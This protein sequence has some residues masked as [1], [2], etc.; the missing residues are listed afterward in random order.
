MSLKDLFQVKKV[1]AP[2]SNEQIAEEVESVQLMDSYSKDKNRVEF[3]VNYSTASNFAIFGSAE[4]YY[5]DTIQ[6][7][8]SQYPYDGSKKEKL[9]WYNSSSLLDIWF[10]ENAYPKTTGY[11]TFS[12]S[13]WGLSSS[14]MVSG[15]GNPASKEYI[16]I[17]GGPNTNSALTLKGQFTDTSNQYPKSNILDSSTNRLS[18]LQ[19]NLNEGVTLEFWLN[20]S[21]FI[22]SST[23]KEVIFDLWNN[24][25]SSSSGYGR[26]TLELSG[27]TGSPFYITAQSGTNGVFRQNIGSTPTTSS[28]NG[29]NHYAVSLYNTSSVIQAKFYLNGELDSTHSLGTSINEITGALIANIGAL[30]TA[31]SGT[32][33]ISLGWGKLSASIDDFRFWKEARTSREIGRNYWDSVG[34]GVNTDDANTTLG[35]Y[36]KFNEGI[37]TTSS[38][39][40][41]V[42]DYSG[43][44]S[45]GTW[46]GYTAPSRNTGS[47]ITNEAPDPIIYITHPDVVAVAEE[48]SVIGTDYDRTNNNSIYYSFP[49]WII[50]EDNNGELLN[51]TQIAASYLDTLY[52][53]IKYFTSLKDHYTNIQIDEKP[54][55]FSQTILESL[56]MVAPSLFIDAKLMEEVLSKDEERNYEDKLH[57]IKNIIYQNIYSNLLNI[58]K[59]K[60]T[61]Q[62]YRN[63]LRCFGIDE[64]L[65]KLNIYSNNGQYRLT[66]NTSNI[67]VK[68]NSISLN[69]PD[70]FIGTI[71]QYPETG[72]SNSTSY[73]SGSTGTELDYVPYTFEAEVVFP[74]KLEQDNN[75]YFPTL[76]VTSSIFGGHTALTSSTT[77]LTWGSPDYFNFKVYAVRKE[78]ESKDV[79]FVLSSSSPYPITELST[80]FYQEVY[81]NEKWNFAVRVKPTDYDANFVS[82]TADTTYTLEFYGV[83]SDGDT[84]KN[85]FS[86]STILTNANGLNFVRQPK[87]LYFGAEATNFTGSIINPTDIKLLNLRAWSSYLTNDTIKRHAADPLNYGI[88]DTTQ[89][90]YLYQFNN[91]SVAKTQTL[92]LNWNFDLVSGSDNGS[93]I[94]NVSDGK[95][96][97][98]DST[99]GSL[100]DTRY[101]T[102]FNN[103]RNYQYTGRGDFFLQNDTTMVDPQY[104][105]ASKLNQFEDIS[106]S[107]LINILTTEEQQTILQATRPVN[108]FFSFEKNMYQTISDEML[109]MFGTILDFN[110]L[111]GEPVNKYR[112]EYKALGK[113]RQL[114]FEKVQNEPDLDK[115]L[116]FYKWIDSA[117]GKFLLQLTPASADTS[118]GLLNVVESH[119]LER[120]KHQHKFPTIEFKLPIIEAGAQT[121]NRHLYNWKVGYHPLS[122]D[123]SDNC[124]YWNQRA[125]R[126]VTPLSSSN[127]D[128]NATRKQILNVSLQALNR[129]FTTPYHF[130]LDESKPIQGGVNFDNN[131]NLEFATIALAPHGPMDADSII[132]VPANYL[133]AGIPN[134]SSLLQD[135]NDVLDPNKKVKYHFTTIHGRD[136][137]SSSLSY[138]EVLS[139]KIALPANFI[140]GTINT[141]YQS[142]VASE[143]M[144]GVVI[145]NI[146][147]DTYGSRNEVPIQGPFTNQWVGGR[148]SRHVPLNQGTDTYTTR[149]EAWK[150]LMGTGSFSGSYQTAIGFVGADYPYPEGNEDEPSYPVRAHLRATYLREET[151][152]R[153]VNFKNIRNST[154]SLNLGNYDR[155]YQVV[156]SVGSTINNRALLDAVN[157]T[158]NTELYGIVRTDVTDG[159]VDYELP[160]RQRSETII[161]NRFS[162]PGDYRTMSRGYLNNY[163]EELSPYN[164]TTFRNRQVIGDGRRNG[165]TLTND[166]T[167]YPEIIS[168]ATGDLNTLL[169]KSSIFGGYQ[170]GSATIPSIHKANRNPLTTV[171]YS[172]ESSTQITKDNDNGFFT[173]P[174]PQNDA[175]YAWIRS[176]V[177]TGSNAYYGYV[178]NR[179]VNGLQVTY[180]SG[181][182]STFNSLQTI[183][184][185][186]FGSYVSQSLF[187]ADDLFTTYYDNARIFGE[188]INVSGSSAFIPVDFV[189][190]QNNI[191][192]LVKN[193][194]TLDFIANFSDIN[195]YSYDYNYLI[196]G[197]NNYKTSLGV[198][199]DNNYLYSTVSDILTLADDVRNG[200]YIQPNNSNFFNSL[201]LNRNG[202]YG[203]PSFKQTRNNYN[204]IVVKQNLD[205][206][207]TLYK[208]NNFIIEKEPL[209]YYN[210]P[211]S[212]LLKNLFTNKL[213]KFKHTYNNIKQVFENTNLLNNLSF[214]EAKTF[215][216]ISL[217]L[218]L[219]NAQYKLL[220][221]ELN[222]NIFPT[223]NLQSTNIINT[224]FDDYFET[225]GYWR[226]MRANRSANFLS[227][228]I[229]SMDNWYSSYRISGSGDYGILQNNSTVVHG[230]TTSTITRSLIYSYKHM[231]AAKYSYLS[232][233]NTNRD[234][235]TSPTPPPFITTDN[236]LLGGTEPWIT[237]QQS[238]KN[239]YYN[240]Y[241]DWFDEINK[242]KYK[243]YSIIP[244]YIISSDA[245][246]S[247]ILNNKLNDDDTNNLKLATIYQSETTTQIETQANTNFIKD[248]EIINNDLSAVSSKIKL[249]LNCDS[250]IKFNPSPDGDL[251]PQNRSYII[252]NQF[253]TSTSAYYT[254]WKDAKGTTTGTSVNSSRRNINTP[255]FAPGVLYNTIKSGIAVDYPILTGTLQVTQS[256]FNASSPIDFQINNSNFDKRIPFES[257]L[258]P[259]IYLNTDLIYSDSHPSASINV[260]SSWSGQYS[261]DLYKLN[262]NNFLAESINFFLADSKLT[263]LYSK[264][265]NEFG[266][267]QPGKCYRTLIKI[268]KSSD[269][270]DITDYQY[271]DTSSYTSYRKPQYP[272]TPKPGTSTIGATET[273]NMY[274]RPSGFGPACAGGISGSSIFTNDII[275]ST[276]GYYAPYTPPYYD[277]EGWALL[278][279]I[280]TGSTSYKPTLEHILNNLEVKYL[281]YEVVEPELGTGGPQG[282]G[283]LNANAMQVSASLNLINIVNLNQIAQNQSDATTTV[284]V[285]KAWAI[286]TKFETPILHFDTLYASTYPTS[287]GQV[288]FGTAGMWHQYG[289]IPTETQGIYLQVTDV[290]EDFSRYGKEFDY[291]TA[292]DT[293]T[294][295]PSLTG[296]LADIV[297]FSKSP[298]KLGKIASSR[299]I[300]E[301]VVAI[302][303]IEENGTRRYIKLNDNAVRYLR[304][305]Y[306]GLSQD[307]EQVETD[308]ALSLSDTIKKQFTTMKDYVFPPN[309]DFINNENIDPI[310][311]YIF[312]FKYTLSQQDLADIWQGLLPDI[313]YKF[314]EQTSVITH[315]LNE[316]ELI[317]KTN[318]NEKLKFFV[319]KVKQ[320]AKNNYFER[321]VNSIQSSDKKKI[322]LLQGLNRTDGIDFSQIDKDLTYSYNWPYDFFSLVELA[323]IDA[324]I[325]YMNE[326]E[327]ILTNVSPKTF[328]GFKNKNNSV[329]IPKGISSLKGTLSNK[330]KT[331]STFNQYQKDLTNTLKNTT[332]DKLGNVVQTSNNLEI[333]QQTN[334]FNQSNVNTSQNSLVN[335]LSLRA[336]LPT[337]FQTSTS[338]PRVLRNIVVEAMAPQA[339][340]I[341][342]NPTNVDAVA[343]RTST[344]TTTNV[345]TSREVNPQ[346]IT[347]V[348]TTNNLSVSTVTK[349]TATN[350]K[351]K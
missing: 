1:L 192:R 257:L 15:Y 222:T 133:F 293:S 158:N 265:E 63:L 148:Q 338:T 296:S 84:V 49:N 299:E 198:Y 242:S 191:I 251:Y 340:Q 329:T 83:N 44:V 337:V 175:G 200:T 48:Y 320:K 304:K 107:N 332:I 103:L 264:P 99:S 28:L 199:L 177:E 210:K 39:D 61:E 186:Q 178:D 31:P 266:F 78:T 258:R 196:G 74:K 268:Y 111:V 297:G 181:S 290:P 7:I 256:Q 276:N 57:E 13:G 37:T 182:T 134:T 80:S 319:F 16:I 147:N 53:Q 322:S 244:E 152:K 215:Y 343:P 226:D 168:G 124:L 225:A 164:V 90:S 180:P 289:T 232:P 8:Y 140:S 313:G 291:R 267:V 89:N 230:G 272:R 106:N 115:Y 211:N 347:A 145:T 12:P 292:A 325:E 77:N 302:P 122:N 333:T 224:Y 76:F 151:A 120:N 35:F 285:S 238:G 241:K 254:R 72:N 336:V 213:L 161:I 250:I 131:K 219:N 171:D 271:Y 306:F 27:T 136:Y 50:D 47:A 91:V 310:A 62:S 187:V 172:G 113:L 269:G 327:T 335:D 135:C 102:A 275:D 105:F 114:F 79:K 305:Q 341:S 4:K 38:I 59:T 22:T 330:P 33:G 348:A 298:S 318:L 183:S 323:K 339:E 190:L 132:N 29:W 260:T 85:E 249:S 233:N 153:I 201:M 157:P 159:R 11:A 214:N 40:S 45:N 95:F 301:A 208:N 18:N 174:I 303:Y 54:Y 160:T 294:R 25:V 36:Y 154:S 119:A 252:A 209:V 110:N 70:R 46:V 2:I 82:G 216:D 197:L 41:I 69:D 73:I 112:K 56:G 96:I 10:L 116:D 142:Q 129:S 328:N 127:G 321:L 253:R 14:V 279:F 9:D 185:S 93:G 284:D 316:N 300:K 236:G 65:V 75:Y 218:F 277:G 101:N 130:K 100:L 240:S 334:V 184:A 349:P 270:I 98:A 108:Y 19:T 81:E 308:I 188:D 5:T 212:L 286:Q 138:G 288:P 317:D 234:K 34:G 17:K 165:E 228:S 144:N 331:Y 123:E 287:S 20:K 274:S 66:D 204:P 314:E 351:I 24:E 60:G 87:R 26:L 246:I 203:Y 143:F 179:Y 141:G 280:P 261:N 3:A 205:N 149:P 55:P 295:D 121:I 92:L 23:Q 235:G 51:L 207:I 312:E 167:Q 137:L 220:N 248:I 324:K 86:L 221:Y 223:K 64:S 169:A 6:R 94:P 282:K 273:I 126:D 32:T 262:I 30:R 42:L 342:S 309:F 166:K 344:T 307:I 68:K 170:S 71:Y 195:S 173:H 97:V 162:A 58:F 259:E 125:E 139:S 245:T 229:W 283:N 155:N 346:T 345:S 193:Y 117:V 88:E 281:R 231:L 255:L 326:E 43:R 21:S 146:H 239:P 315:E 67:T 263:T 176:S 278:T 247:N 52:L 202:P 206:Y 194:T 104:L 350:P 243:S 118:E 217:K 311:M 163:A 237:G 150:I 109:K 227:D 128:T 156:H 189:G